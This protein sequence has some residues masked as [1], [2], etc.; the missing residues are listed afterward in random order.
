MCALEIEFY[1][2]IKEAFAAEL[3]DQPPAF[4]REVDALQSGSRRYSLL[5]NATS[6]LRRTPAWMAFRRRFWPAW[7]PWEDDADA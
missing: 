1:E 5:W 7:T 3:R 2:Q 4:A 6:G